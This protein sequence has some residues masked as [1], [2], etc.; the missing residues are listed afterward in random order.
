[1]QNVLKRYHLVLCLA[2]PLVLTEQQ[3][4]VRATHEVIPLAGADSANLGLTCFSNDGCLVL[5]VTSHD[6]RSLEASIT[7]PGGMR[8]DG[9]VNNAPTPVR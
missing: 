1:M 9:E 5:C 8:C 3:S 7:E 6:A 4:F 2:V